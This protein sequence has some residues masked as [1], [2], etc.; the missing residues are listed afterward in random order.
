MLKFTSPTPTNSEIA[1]SVNKTEGSIRAHKKQHPEEIENI[2]LKYKNSN[3]PFIKVEEYINFNNLELYEDDNL[4]DIEKE[5]N[6]LTELILNKN[7][8]GTIYKHGNNVSFTYIPPIS[9][10]IETIK[11]IFNENNIKKP[12]SISI[13]NHKGG[14]NKTTNTTNIA[15]SLAYFGYKVLIVDFDPQGNASGSFG[16]YENDY[17]YTIIDLITMSSQPD[18]KDIIKK[19]VININL[20]NKFSND[21]LGKLDILPNNASMSEKVEDLP[22]MARNLGTIENTLDRVL[23]YIK[24]DY[25]FILIDLP[26]RTDVILRTAM[27]ASDYFI[28]SLNAQ[29]FARLGMPNIL[30]PIRKYEN[31][32]KQ[33]KGK[34]FV[35]LGGIVGFYE[36]GVTI[37]DIN[38]EQMKEDIIEC[39]KETSSLFNTTIPK[40]TIIQE[41]Q[42]GEGAVL[43]TS[44]TNKIVRNFFDLT[45]EILE[46]IIINKMT[47]EE[48]K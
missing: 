24:D 37:Q 18:I 3:Y 40:S 5:S 14:A 42:Q 20:E 4:K 19:S 29:P 9:K 25:D 23:N 2:N 21:I 12:I 32:Y 26:P 45:L 39:T 41:S 10:E 44:P 34:D 36:K 31:I 13:G 47:I 15:A 35:I 38:Y 43:F 27:I 22:T 28:I 11:N 17:E 48:G 8:P 33:E 16:I 1:K 30:N 46:R 7:I 6:K